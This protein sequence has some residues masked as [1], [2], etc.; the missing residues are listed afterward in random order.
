MECHGKGPIL[1]S[2][3]AASPDAGLAPTALPRRVGTEVLRDGGCPSNFQPSFLLLLIAFRG[4]WLPQEQAEA[5]WFF[6]S[7]PVWL[8]WFCLCFGW[9]LGFG[10][11]LFL[12]FCTDM[13][14]LQWRK[15]KKKGNGEELTA[16]FLWLTIHESFSRVIKWTEREV[17]VYVCVLSWSVI[18]LLGKP[19]SQLGNISTC[20][21]PRSGCGVPAA[22]GLGVCA[23]ET[24]TPCVPVSA[25]EARLS[26]YTQ[27]IPSFICNV[28]V[29]LLTSCAAAY[30]SAQLFI[31]FPCVCICTSAIGRRHLSL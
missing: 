15:K 9:G 11:G 5:D 13:G 17:R 14:N 25:F 16:R 3:S 1:R 12:F 4:L 29:C 10:F 7:L 31:L 21:Y 20:N 19:M 26:A 24:A 18:S 22:L 6:V 30:R 23:A 8:V 2:H 28:C 27:P